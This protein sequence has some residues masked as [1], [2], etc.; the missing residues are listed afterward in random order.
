MSQLKPKR[1][2]GMASANPFAPQRVKKQKF[3]SRWSA[4]SKTRAAERAVEPD[5]APQP[6]PEPPAAAAPA[7]AGPPP[8]REL[9]ASPQRELK[10]SPPREAKPDWDAPR[11]PALKLKP[12]PAPAPAP[13]AAAAQSARQSRTEK[14]T[15]GGRQAGPWDAQ[16]AEL[17]AAAQHT[18]QSKA[19]ANRRELE[20]A[21]SGAAM[22]RAAAAAGLG[23]SSDSD[24]EDSDG[25]FTFKMTILDLK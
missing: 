14:L 18:G 8:Q 6:E 19:A 1:R 3:A 12:A 24:S 21:A 13:P 15:D 16:A 4:L 11:E 17:A 22:R 7:T 23:S 2:N 10:A 5:P 20:E 25:V 9:K